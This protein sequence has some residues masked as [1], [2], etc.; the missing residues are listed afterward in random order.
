MQDRAC[1]RWHGI[2]CAGNCVQFVQHQ[3]QS[4]GEGWP[5][6][7]RVQPF[8][9]SYMIGVGQSMRFSLL[10][11]LANPHGNRA[12][13]MP[14]SSR[15]TTSTPIIS[16]ETLSSYVPSGVTWGAVCM[17]P[18]RVSCMCLK[19]GTMF[20][21]GGVQR[22]LQEL[23]A[24]TMAILMLPLRKHVHTLTLY[25]NVCPRALSPTHQR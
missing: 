23:S 8:E 2:K 10:P 22:G 21:H 1:E 15:R 9:A 3:L 14:N 16:T 18:A 11:P 4:L 24:H 25:C 20:M 7:D 5:S 13:S 17:A 12:L 19:R 6:L